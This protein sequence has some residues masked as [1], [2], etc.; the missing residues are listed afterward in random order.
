[1][2]FLVRARSISSRRAFPSVIE[3]GAFT[4][5]G[6]E[7]LL[8]GAG[9]DA[10][11]FGRLVGGGELR[12]RGEERCVQGQLGEERAR[13]RLGDLIGGADL[14]RGGHRLQMPSDGDGDLEL[15]GG[16][17]QRVQG[18]R[19]GAG[20]GRDRVDLA[21]SVGDERID[22]R[23]DVFG[24]DA[25]EGDVE[26]V[27][28]VEKGIGVGHARSVATRRARA[29]RYQSQGFMESTRPFVRFFRRRFARGVPYGLGFTLA[30]LALC[31][32]L[33]GFVEIVEAVTIEHDL[34]HIDAVAHSAVYDF[35]GGNPS[36]GL[37][38]TWFGNASTITVF[39]VLLT[40][41]LAMAHRY[42]A[43]FRVAFASGAGAVVALG[44]KAF[45]ARVRPI[46]QLVPAHGYSFPSG[47][48]FAS[49]VF[50][51][52]AVYLVWRMTERRWAR[53]LALVLGPLLFLMVGLSRVYLNVHFITDVVGGWLS[54][55]A[56]LGA[57][58]LIVDIVESRT[59]SR[60]EKQS[61]RV[62]TEGSDAEPPAV[63]PGA[64][65]EGEDGR[66]GLE[67]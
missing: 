54:G 62:D 2:V 19:V 26:G 14:G 45:F 21:L 29:S 47:H 28:L 33:W 66:L 11:E 63:P 52:M 7:G 9:V 18:A 1:M 60:R 65:G 22:R 34:E 56:W 37:A 46:D 17:L 38:V 20:R 44:L 5:V 3:L 13:L 55:L 4:T 40:L 41:G 30:F 15:L 16:L 6:V 58:I 10:V 24:A 64:K 53:L 50:Y 23:L 39:T 36:L 31:A 61:D 57:N 35:F 51:G 43:A 32:A 27:G 49:T 25:I 59:R 48:A 67:H 12:E 42:W 8:E